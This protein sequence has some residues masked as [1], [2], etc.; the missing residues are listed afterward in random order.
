MEGL[1]T[2]LMDTVLRLGNGGLGGVKDT[3][4]FEL[5]LTK[6]TKVSD[7]VPLVTTVQVRN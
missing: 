6:S 2:E 3:S 4:K 7:F 5:K 1:R